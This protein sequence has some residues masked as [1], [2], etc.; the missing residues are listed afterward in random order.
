VLASVGSLRAEELPEDGQ[1]TQEVEQRVRNW[2]LRFGPLV[3]DTGGNSRVVTDPDSA[4]LSF[5]GGGGAAISLERRL[6]PLLG[7]EFGIATIGSNIDINTRAIKH[8]STDLDILIISPLF[9]GVNFHFVHDGPVDVYAGPLLAYNRYSELSVESWVDDDWWSAKH[10]SGTVTVR[11]DGDS[12]LTWGV[13]TGLD[14]YLGE[15]K[16]WSL[17]FALS[18][19]NATY[20]YE[21]ESFADQSSVSLDPLI[22]GFGAGFRF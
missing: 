15:R 12:E 8:A 17:N 18:Y 21:R 22:F 2:H 4:S 13:K 16:R 6:S 10:D 5:S 7:I 19:L 3:A 1:P 20:E 9:V 11:S 14:V